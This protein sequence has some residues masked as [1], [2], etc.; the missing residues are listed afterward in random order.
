[1][2]KATPRASCDCLVRLVMVPLRFLLVKVLFLTP[3]LFNLWRRQVACFHLWRPLVTA[4]PDI[5][6]R[7]SGPSRLK[8]LESSKSCSWRRHVVAVTSSPLVHFRVFWVFVVFRPFSLQKRPKLHLLRFSPPK[9]LKC[10]KKRLWVKSN[11]K[12]YE[13]RL[14]RTL[15]NITFLLS[16][17]TLTLEICLSSSKWAFIPIKI[18]VR[19]HLMRT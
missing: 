10:E 15:K 13:L 1:M 5:T 2:V 4:S 6:S 7:S 3:S 16:S 14:K 19:G 8:F 17:N 11:H 18:Q 9:Y 12:M